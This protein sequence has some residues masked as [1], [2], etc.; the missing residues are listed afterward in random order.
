MDEREYSL[1]EHLADLRVRVVRACIGLGIVTIAMFP[2]IPG[3]TDRSISELLLEWLRLPMI[4]LLQEHAGPSAHF[5]V[6][7]AADYVICQMKAA[8]VA[9]VFLASPWILY[10]VWLF[11]AP[12]LYDK[13]KRYV[14]LFVWAGAFCF[15]GG[16]VF[17]YFAVFPTMFRFLVTSL[18]PDLAMTPSLE[19]HFSFTLKMLLAFGV[20]FETPVLIFILSLAGIIDP[21]SVGKYR[22]YV[23]IGAF[24]VGAVL[25]PTPDFL[26][27]TLL[28]GPMIVL[29]ELGVLVSRLVVGVAGKPLDRTENKDA[30][31]ETNKA[32]GGNP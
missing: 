21:N 5:V 8:L 27:Q 10:Q 4:K 23:I 30:A 1:F 11:I 3:V 18:P 17:A 2:P 24:I 16:A 19:E 7:G 29:F 15:V 25:T 20:V 6:L 22:K 12:G 26:S 32:A 13:E 9:G 28:A 14:V 31:S